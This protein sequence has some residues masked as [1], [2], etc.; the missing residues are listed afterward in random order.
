MA[1]T[2]PDNSKLLVISFDDALRAQ[3]FL[4]A[5]AGLQQRD[6]LKIHDAVIISRAAGRHVPRA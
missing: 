3:E 2:A 5:A 1:Q 4:L 6:E